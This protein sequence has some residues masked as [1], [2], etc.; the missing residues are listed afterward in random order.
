MMDTNNKRS[1]ILYTT[2]GC[3]LCEQAEQLFDET[4][5]SLH[6]TLLKIDIANNDALFNEYGVSIPVIKSLSTEQKLYWP[7]DMNELNSFINAQ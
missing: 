7:F 5:N 3:H 4:T 6:T 1:F 2:V